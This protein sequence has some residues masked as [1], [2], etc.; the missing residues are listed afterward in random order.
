VY[1][2]LHTR[3]HAATLH[4]LPDFF[5][6]VSRLLPGTVLNRK[7]FKVHLGGYNFMPY[8]QGK[9]K[10]GPGNPFYYFDHGGN[11]NADR[12]RDWKVNFATLQENIATGTRAV[13]AWALISNLRMDPYER[14]FEEFGMAI[15]FLARNTTRKGVSSTPE[16]SAAGH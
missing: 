5:S 13:P 9:L 16:T 14:T 6:V 12:Y 2:K 3:Y 8:I 7:K 4:S 15:D 10:E 1:A 11:L